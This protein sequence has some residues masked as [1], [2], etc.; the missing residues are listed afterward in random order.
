MGLVLIVEDEDQV[1]VLAESYLREN[2]H[3]TLSAS[4]V[5]EALALLG[6]SDGVDILFTDI[7]L[8]GDVHGGLNLAK[9]AVERC[10]QLKVLYATGQAVT[11]G[12]KA[13]MVEGS[14]ILEKPYTVEQLDASL[15]V[16]FRVLPA[17]KRPPS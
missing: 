9:Q 10:P 6:V 16:H 13:M 1:R 2:G 11:D 15:A 17:P 8:Q 3:R 5:A 4:T 14:A 12:M 7:V